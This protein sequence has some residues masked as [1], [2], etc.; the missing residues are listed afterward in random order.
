MWALLGARPVDVLAWESFG[1]GWAED[2]QQ[3]LKLEARLLDADYGALPDL[4]AVDFD[5]DVVFTWNG[6][7]SGVRVPNADWI[8]HDR[9]GLVLCDATSA[10]FAMDVEFEKLDVVTWSW[11]KVLG[12]EAAHG[13]LALSPR[14]VERLQQHTPGLA[15]AQ[16]LPAGGEGQA[17]RE[18]LRRR[19]D[20]HAVD[21]LRRGRARRAGVGR[22]RGRAARPDPSLG[23]EPL[24]HHRL[25][26]AYRRGSTSWRAIR[27]R[28]RA[29]RSACRSPTRTSTR[30][31][32]ARARPRWPRW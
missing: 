16:D 13:M 21:A 18:P 8:P 11:Q 24:G 31:T 1:A 14:A 30:R 32:P 6:T 23:G 27:P 7:T 15:A 4:R 5:R 17:A 9:A 28:A 20:Q 12:G 25:G 26:G 22:A 3:Q 19:H 29:P 2:I 10:V